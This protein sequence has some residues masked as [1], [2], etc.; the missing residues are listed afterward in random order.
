MPKK[1]SVLRRSEVLRAARKKLWFEP[2][3]RIRE[4]LKWMTDD[5]AEMYRIGALEAQE[6]IVARMLALLPETE[7][8]P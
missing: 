5:P 4:N 6:E 7:T 3:S 2:D 8:E 1:R